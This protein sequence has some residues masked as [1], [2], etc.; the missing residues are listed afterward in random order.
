M[1]A[2]FLPGRPDPGA[3]TS[4]NRRPGGIQ[5][6][7]RGFTR[8]CRTSGR[9]PMPVFDALGETINDLGAGLDDLE[10]RV[11]L[12]PGCDVAPMLVNNPAFCL[13][14]LGQPREA[15]Q[16]LARLDC[17]QLID[18]E[19][20]VIAATKG[21]IA[22]RSGNPEE[23]RRL[24]ADAIRTLNSRANRAIAMLMLAVEEMRLAAPEREWSS[25]VA[26]R[27]AK[28][29][30]AGDSDGWLRH[31]EEAESANARK[32]PKQSQGSAGDTGNM[33]E[34]SLRDSGRLMWGHALRERISVEAAMS[35]A[36]AV[37]CTHDR[38]RRKQASAADLCFGDVAA[39][40]GPTGCAQQRSR[41]IA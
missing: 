26:R 31:L 33:I 3:F 30:L 16:V 27:G 2:A 17:S 6:R 1:R 19:R 8:R 34:T 29:N 28:A 4:A 40:P 14:R 38:I 21:L 10:G 20:P 12:A 39:I 9:S 37:P 24:Y 11:V 13:A 22:F 25:T 7:L 32:E 35:T 15:Q 5:L 36:V 41:G 23:G 18:D